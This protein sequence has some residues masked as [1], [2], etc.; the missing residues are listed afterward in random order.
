[1]SM[2]FGWWATDPERGKHQILVRIHGGNIVWTRKQGH[3]TSWE[4]YGPPN[5]ADWEKLLGEAARRV[6]RRLLSP[7]QFAEIEKLR[8]RTR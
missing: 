5:D 1:M 3:H 7:K 2:E 4:A 8:A 6:P